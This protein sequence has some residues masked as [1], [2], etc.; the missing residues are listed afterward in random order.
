[1]K[2]DRMF[3]KGLADSNL[4]YPP[5]IPT[6]E[7]EERKCR[8]CSNKFIISH[9]GHFYCSYGCYIEKE[10]VMDDSGFTPGS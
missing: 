2:H 5:P 10:K 1:M 4:P 8:S 6:R 9:L 7:G 3:K